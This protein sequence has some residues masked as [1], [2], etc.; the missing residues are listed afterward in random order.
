MLEEVTQ[1]V[2]DNIRLSPTLSPSRKMS[3]ASKLI[4]YIVGN[5]TD[6]NTETLSKE[7]ESTFKGDIV[8]E[9]SNGQ[10][11]LTQAD[12]TVLEGVW[13]DG[14]L[15]GFGRKFFSSGEVE[16]EGNFK[17]NVF[18][19]RGVLYNEKSEKDDGAKLNPKDLSNIEAL[20]TKYEG[21]FLEGKKHGD[22]VLFFVNNEKFEGTFADDK[23]EGE[24]KYKPTEGDVVAGVWK[25]GIYQE[26]E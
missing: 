18:H 25:D 7:P 19:G 26:S 15:E 17:G 23:I 20:W 12:G 13:Q 21:E 24:G 14:K 11:K 3:T 16:Y 10:S 5:P 22:G 8:Q 2:I 6:R 1:E 4:A 9:K